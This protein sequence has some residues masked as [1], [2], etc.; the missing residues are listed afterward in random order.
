MAGSGPERHWPK[1]SSK[2]ADSAGGLDAC[3]MPGP[4]DDASGGV[5]A[6]TSAKM[7][8][9]SM[10]AGAGTAPGAREGDCC[11]AAPHGWASRLPSA[12]RLTPRGV[13]CERNVNAPE[14]DILA[15]AVGNSSWAPLEP[16]AGAHVNSSYFFLQSSTRSAFEAVGSGLAALQVPPNF[17]SAALLPMRCIWAISS[18]PQR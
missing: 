3:I 8:S 14:L 18:G 7:A 12:S 9:Q 4:N 1:K 5:K 6:L 13:S 16:G 10:S 2:A 15:S 11:Q 17:A